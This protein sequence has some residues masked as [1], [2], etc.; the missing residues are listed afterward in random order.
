MKSGAPDTL[1][2]AT[3]WIADT[4]SMYF[5]EVLEAM[6]VDQPKVAVVDPA[7]R[8]GD[9]PPV[10][11]KQTLSHPEGAALWIGAS[12]SVSTL[13]A[14]KV[15]GA[16]G[17]VENDPDS[18]RRTYEEV[19]QQTTSALARVLGSKFELDVTCGEGH[20]DPAGPPVAGISI[21]FQFASERPAQVLI[22]V[23]PSLVEEIGRIEQPAEM[24][25]TAAAPQ[26]GFLDSA[27][28]GL[29][30][31]AYVES[32]PPKTIDLILDVE[33]PVSVSFG[34]A[35]LP[36]K[37]VLR[38]TSGA[39]VELNRPVADPVEVIVNNCVIAR[40]EVVVIDGNYGV[41]INQII[42]RHDRL[43]TLT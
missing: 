38:L 5:R 6:T 12:A 43:R 28:P 3:R 13:L 25:R 23:H 9:E 27:T 18:I 2:E 8:T 40:G 24:E 20:E 14:N 21:D 1:Q 17:V 37:E 15:L 22:A 4:W 33:L 36:L 39:I 30:A 26:R 11:L 34:R 10:W 16:A 7:M 31:P 42:S 19:V 29:T 32:G 41:R 35:Y